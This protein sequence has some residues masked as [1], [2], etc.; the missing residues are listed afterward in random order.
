MPRGC[1]TVQCRVPVTHMPIRI[2]IYVHA[3]AHVCT[4]QYCVPAAST[5][6]GTRRCRMLAGP[7]TMAHMAIL[8]SVWHMLP[9][10]AWYGTCCRANPSLRDLSRYTHVR[11]THVRS[12]MRRR[13]CACD[14]MRTVLCCA[15]LSRA[16]PC[17]AVPCR[18]VLCRA[19]PCR[20]VPC[21]A[22]PCR[23]VPCRRE[24]GRLA[25]HACTPCM[26]EPCRPY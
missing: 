13:V 15:V 10:C 20:A 8:C 6:T 5:A 16:V 26:W 4:V 14:C 9:S 11:A 18:A 21:R 12:R 17:C 23:A 22:V 19:V 2:S 1:S 3:Y 25:L 7:R 24:T